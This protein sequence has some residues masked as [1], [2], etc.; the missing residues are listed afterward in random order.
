MAPVTLSRRSFLGG[1]AVVAA[2]A[3]TGCSPSSSAGGGGSGSA[4]VTLPKYIRYEGVTPDL[5][6][7]ASGIPDTFLRYPAKPVAAFSRPP[8]DGS[9][10]RG[11][12]PIGGPVP[13]SAG[14]NAYW[15]ELN[16]RLGS[17]LQLT[18]TPRADFPQRFA[19]AVAGDGLGDLY[20]LDM[21]MAHLPDFLR[22]QCQDLTE[23]LAGDAIADYPFLA[24]IATESWRGTVFGGGIYAVPIT[25]GV[26]SSALLYARGDL[27]AKHGI[28]DD[29]RTV[30]DFLALCAEVTE[31]RANTW[32]L[33]SAP[34]PMLQQMLGLPNNWQVEGGTF[35]HVLELDG[36]RE[37]LELGR[38]LVD[39]G[40]VVPDGVTAEGVDQKTWFASGAALLHADT[41][42]AAPGLHQQSEASAPDYAIRMVR[43]PSQDGK[44]PAALWL[45]PPNNTLSAIKKGDPERVRTLLSVLNWLAAPLGTEEHLFRKFGVEGVHYELDGTDPVLTALGKSETSEGF[46]PVEYLVDGPRSNYFPGRPDVAKDVHAHMADM[47]PGGVADPTVGLYSDTQGTKGGQLGTALSDATNAILLGRKPVS[48]WDAVVA[49]W[50]ADGGDKIRA[51]YEAAYAEAN[52]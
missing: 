12:V 27:L 49:K 15:Q 24:N 29:P 1:V 34:M 30:D 20:T 19:T 35:T 8:G 9:E 11:S 21:G 33:S 50:R 46:F 3:L 51:E 43:T 48:S 17:D 14:R 7:D 6:G 42:S 47:V 25:R 16:T 22:A 18:M 5:P 32:A 31:P 23:H 44:A 10:I 4:S 38:R 28:T 40:Y 41:Y 36:H 39:E 52:G 13:P 2:G 45:G 26:Q 37:A